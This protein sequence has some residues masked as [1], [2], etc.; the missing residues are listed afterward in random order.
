MTNSE[1]VAELFK[2]LLVHGWTRAVISGWVNRDESGLSYDAFTATK[3]AD[4]TYTEVLRDNCDALY[5]IAEAVTAMDIKGFYKYT[6][7]LLP[8][9]EVTVD[10]DTCAFDDNVGEWD[11]KY[12]I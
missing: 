2:S 9:G 3:K 1:K 8:T 7:V 6:M 12:L 11:T 10:E 4:G 5:N